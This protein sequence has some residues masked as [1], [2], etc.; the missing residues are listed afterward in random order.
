MRRGRY[1]TRESVTG[2]GKNLSPGSRLK[3]K[4]T[5]YGGISPFDMRHKRGIKRRIF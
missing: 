1:R 3:Y 4:T 2:I 5:N